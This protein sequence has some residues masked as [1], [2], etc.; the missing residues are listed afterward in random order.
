MYAYEESEYGTAPNGCMQFETISNP[1]G[2][3]CS[4]NKRFATVLYDLKRFLIGSMQIESTA[5]FLGFEGTVSNRTIPY[6]GGNLNE[7]STKDYLYS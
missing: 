2:L 6:A 5:L 1:F 7:H 3:I 4:G